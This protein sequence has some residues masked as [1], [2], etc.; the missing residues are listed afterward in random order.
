MIKSLALTECESVNYLW[1][2]LIQLLGRDKA[3]QAIRQAFDLQQM[4]GNG[5]TLPVLFME[6]CGVAL[7]TFDLL[8]DQTGLSFIEKNNKVLLL[9]YR[10]KTFQVLH[11]SN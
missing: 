6:T 7:T 10:K 8:R 9:S 2:E 4:R 1:T 5:E 3:F 11:N